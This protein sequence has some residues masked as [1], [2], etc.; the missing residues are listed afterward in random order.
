MN[1]FEK[2]LIVLPARN[3]QSQIGAVLSKLLAL[4]PEAQILVVNDFSSDN[5]SAIV[6]HFPSVKL[7]ELPFW[8][9]YGGALQTGYKYALRKGF[10]RLVQMD[11]DGQH[12]P[13]EVIKLLEQ[14]N[15]ADI[16]VG[17]RFVG[18]TVAYKMP[19]VRRLGCKVLSTMGF[20]LTRMRI[21]DPTSGFQALSRHALEV[22]CNDHYP[23]DYPDI[24]VLIL[25]HRHRLRVKEIPVQMYPAEEKRG[26]HTGL[27]VWYYAIKMT[28]SMIVIMLRR[29]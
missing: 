14:L 5:T 16:V 27:Q 2:S 15:D 29:A 1:L 10:D 17:S 18:G 22:A 8:L 21:A 3:E 24:D 20:L 25:M 12:D 23:L 26:M 6:R 19:T 28:L 9:G 13:S 11:A 4:Y 7:I